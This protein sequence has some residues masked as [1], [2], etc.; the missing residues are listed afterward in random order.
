MSQEVRDMEEMC[1][2]SG[3]RR[4]TS[5][6]R[7][8]TIYSNTR[9]KENSSYQSY[10]DQQLKKIRADTDSLNQK[11][12]EDSLNLTVDAYVSRGLTS[13]EAEEYVQSLRIQKKIEERMKSLGHLFQPTSNENGRENS[14]NHCF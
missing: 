7:N 1:Q 8:R 9:S 4:Q 6:S 13:D 12:K 11:R 14:V 10:I 2:G 3:T 5:N